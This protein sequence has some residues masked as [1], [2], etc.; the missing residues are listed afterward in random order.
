VRAATI[1]ST[2]T[3]TLVVP[4]YDEA[5]RL[6]VDALERLAAGA[7]V[8]LILVDDGSTDGTL[9]RMRTLAARVPDAINVISR[10]ANAGKGETVRVGMLLALDA[11]APLVG[12]FD[13]DLATPPAEIARLVGIAHDRPDLDVVLGSRVGLLGHRIHRSPG[14]HYLGRVFATASSLV[15]GLQVYDTQCGAKVFRATPAL[16]A[17]LSEPF[18]SRWAF[19][20][21]LLFRLTRRNGAIEPISADAMLE[22][23]LDEWSDVGGSKLGPREAVR[24]AVDLARLGAER[25]RPQPEGSSGSS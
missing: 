22:V 12:Y 4:C 2:S 15:L 21:E 18:R 9:G 3:A 11:G 20:V 1:V 25:L 24:A 5:L 14:R 7:G 23:P 13:A 6:D 10:P 19:D 8:A 16:R 17:A